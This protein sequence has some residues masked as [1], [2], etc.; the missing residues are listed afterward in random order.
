MSKIILSGNW[1]VLKN[2]S[3]KVDDSISE[4]RQSKNNIVDGPKLLDIIR[5]VQSAT[6]LT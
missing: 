3:M 4:S 5:I 6:T 1:T 2:R